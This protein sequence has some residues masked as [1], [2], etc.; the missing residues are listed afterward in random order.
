MEKNLDRSLTWVPVTAIVVGSVIGSGIFVSSAGMA[1][2]V[3][4]P[5][6]LMLVWLVAGIMTL[7][8]AFTQCELT[9]QSPVTG[10][11]Y[12]YLLEAYG[13]VVGFFYGWANFMI[14]GSGAIAAI[15]FIF[16][17]YV[18]EIIPLPHLSPALEAWQ[19]HIPLL[20]DLNPLKD[21]GIKFLGVILIC[22][23]TGLNVRG[24]RLGAKLQTYSTSA[25][26]IA[27]VLVILA[28][29]LFGHGN[30]SN[31]IHPQTISSKGWSSTLS[32]FA[33]A[34]SGAFWSYDG[35]GAVAYIAGEVKSP[36]KTIPKSILIGAAIFTSVYLL[37]N[38]AYLY[39]LPID[40]LGQVPQD[41]VA[42]HVMNNVFGGMGASA[43]ALLVI[44]STFDT[45]NSTI[46]TNA[47][48]Y[49][50]MARRKVFFRSAGEPHSLYKTP[51]IALI[52]QGVWSVLLIMT[53]SFDI[54]TSMYVF[55]N[56]IL[57]VLMGI[58]VFI[59]RKKN[60]GKKLA[61][62]IPGYPWVPLI[63]VVFATLFVVMTLIADLS[64]YHEGKQPFL[65]SVTGLCMVGVGFPLYIYF[66]KINE[67]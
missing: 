58:A 16:A 25:K 5:F 42:S 24:V 37:I 30:T 57:Y 4:D 12:E 17:S 2:T 50:A 48:V 35:W 15:A 59:F 1:R 7:F 9:A 29:F 60:R 38:L 54:I 67:A 64:A 44:L 18:G 66:K 40:Q 41:R 6:L 46:L 65:Q 22:F 56:W 62:T 61:F 21:M 31:W 33:L 13:E 27:V 3:G 43:I 49:Y 63:Y 51:H 45:T 39:I 23:L 52:L 19:L 47:R 10:G 11:L 53:G 34:L 28:A 8:G 14:A 32:I 55:V 36:E 20:G 26:V